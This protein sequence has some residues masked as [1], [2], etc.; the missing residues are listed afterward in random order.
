MRSGDP[1]DPGFLGPNALNNSRG[2]GFLGP[3][4]H[5]NSRGT[6]IFGPQ[7]AQKFQRIQDF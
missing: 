6:R 5:N 2:S 7:C 4:A 3:N 1:Q